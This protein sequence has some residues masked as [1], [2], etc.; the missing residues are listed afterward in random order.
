MQWSMRV[1]LG[2]AM[3]AAG[4]AAAAAGPIPL[5]LLR[6][7][8]ALHSPALSPDGKRLAFI[9]DVEGRGTIFVEALPGGRKVQ[10]YRDAKRS[11][12]NVVWSSDGRW[13]LSFQDA[14]GDEGFHL[15]RIDPL[16]PAGPAQD[17]TPFKG[18]TAELIALPTQIPGAAVISLNMRDPA[19]S[20]A[21]LVDLG[22]GR[23]TEV[24]RNTGEFTEFVADE[25]GRVLAG[26]M[27]KPDGRMQIAARATPSAPW[28]TVYSS[29]VTE[30]FKLLRLASGGLAAYVRSNRGAPVDRLMRLDLR[31]GRARAIRTATCGRFDQ[32]DAF[33]DGRGRAALASCTTARK[34]LRP[35][36]K[37]M[38][39]Q[40]DA[41]RH[42]A[43]T[44]AGLTLESTTPDMT[45]AVYYAD[46]S[47][48]PGAYLLFRK[49]R[50]TRL[51]D[52]RPWLA[53]VAMARSRLVW[54]RARDGL[55]LPLYVTRPSG[56]RGPAPT[57]LVLHG[58]PWSRDTGGFEP[59]TQLYAS[60]GYAVIQVNFRGSTGFGARHFEAGVHQFGAAMS[61]DVLDALD[62]AVTQ[63]IADPKRVCVEGGSYGGYATL[64]ALTR[65]VERFRCGIDYAGPVDLATLM[66]AFPPSWGRFLPRSWSR[67]V[68]DPASPA[69][70][71]LMSARSP[72]SHLDQLRAPLLVFQG[73]ND[74][75]VTQ[76]Q[77]DRVVCALRKRGV[78]VDYLLA[79]NEGHSFGNVETALAVSRAAEEFLAEEL[80][81]SVAAEVDPG[82]QHVL[83]GLREAGRSI[84]C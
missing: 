19:N 12:S 28:R 82:L 10:L 22:S 1:L 17:L 37:S 70:R 66:E 5:E 24:A 57:V 7:A 69:E 58:G 83:N 40:I 63:R 67:F 81:G 53:G 48:R 29:P 84:V 45:S 55:P 26:A 77:S 3:A 25:R 11:L 44:D 42:F 43:G 35:L 14:G 71:A 38:R 31:T 61:D 75:R 78:R 16:V 62:W 8:P 27:V 23:L 80:G 52:T 47:D 51:A 21:Y 30:R 74:P 32:E 68:G 59:E 65:D 9:S 34:E 56:A 33:V 20:D 2:M 72:L 41:V 73:A 76:S 54:A 79:A 18:A 64:V 4:G 46:R 15:F 60:R 6:R 13:L 49:S 39:S 50:V 36:N